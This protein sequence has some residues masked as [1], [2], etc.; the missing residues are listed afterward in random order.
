MK[1]RILQRN[2]TRSTE[3]LSVIWILRVL[4]RNAHHGPPRGALR[5]APRPQFASPAA[6]TR[7]DVA[8]ACV[9]GPRALGWSSKTSRSIFSSICCAIT[10]TVGAVFGT[11][12]RPRVVVD[13]LY[14][15]AHAAS[16]GP[17]GLGAVS[18]F[19]DDCPKTRRGSVADVGLGRG[20]QHRRRRAR[21]ALPGPPGRCS[22]SPAPSR[23]TARRG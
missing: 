17:T 22:G 20:R 11:N 23:R 15:H 3:P 5:A 6:Q 21:A 9:P 7:Q 16:T 4:N 2:A 19:G 13:L 18:K 1:Y 10:I 14:A 12:S 8:H